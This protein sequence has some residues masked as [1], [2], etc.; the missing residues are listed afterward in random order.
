MS[1]IIL[2]ALEVLVLAYCRNDR[3]ARGEVTSCM[4][5]LRKKRDRAVSG[6]SRIKESDPP[7]FINTW[8]FEIG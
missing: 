8:L 1:R 6:A 2:V 5:I 4:L 3:R 7:N